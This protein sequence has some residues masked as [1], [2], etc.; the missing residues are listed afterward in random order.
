MPFMMVVAWYRA[1]AKLISKIH[2]FVS[3]VRL[4]SLMLTMMQYMNDEGSCNLSFYHIFT[5]FQ[6]TI[7]LR[8]I[9]II[10]AMFLVYSLLAQFVWERTCSGYQS[11]RTEAW[12]KG[13]QYL[14]YKIIIKLANIPQYHRNKNIKL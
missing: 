11:P 8:K 7:W 12:R 1:T 14:S 6:C 13:F 5:P 10:F 4:W 3:S 9:F 2:H